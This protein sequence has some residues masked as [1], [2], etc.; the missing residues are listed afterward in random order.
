MKVA[1]FGGTGFVGSYIIDQLLDSGHK[2]R[3]LVREG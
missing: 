2:P 1:L 3:L